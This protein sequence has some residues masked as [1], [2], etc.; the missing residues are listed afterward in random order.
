VHDTDTLSIQ[1]DFLGEMPE[2]REVYGR[3]PLRLTQS[4]HNRQQENEACFLHIN[5]NFLGTEVTRQ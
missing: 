3:T 4:S 5:S 1:G 2:V